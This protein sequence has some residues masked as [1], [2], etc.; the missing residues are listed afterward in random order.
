MTNLQSKEKLTIFKIRFRHNKLG[1]GKQ[2]YF[3]TAKKTFDKGRIQ[4]CIF[5]S[6]LSIIEW[7]DLLEFFNMFFRC[8]SISRRDMCQSVGRSVSVFKIRPKH[9]EIC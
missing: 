3:L 6:G 8:D 7:K 4:V 9:H 5:F 1:M 2:T